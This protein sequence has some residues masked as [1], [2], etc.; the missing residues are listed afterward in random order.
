MKQKKRVDIFKIAKQLSKGIK[1]QNKAI[2]KLNIITKGNI[3]LLKNID[4]ELYNKVII[5]KENIKTHK[6]KRLENKSK[7][8]DYLGYKPFVYN[9]S[10]TLKEHI[11]QYFNLT[12]KEY[13]E[14]LK[15]GC[16]YCSKKSKLHIHHITPKSK[17]GDNQRDNLIPL[18]G[19]CHLTAHNKTEW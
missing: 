9:K 1:E 10:I 12:M 2:S 3:E 7:Q 18:C 19:S 16:S 4:K 6:I 11:K 8:L 15:Q 5:A 14:I 13:K 17:G